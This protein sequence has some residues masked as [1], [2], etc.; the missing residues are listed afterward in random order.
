MAPPIAVFPNAF[1]AL[2]IEKSSIL[3]SFNSLPDISC[4]IELLL[5]DHYAWGVAVLSLV[6]FPV[7]VSIL[8]ELLRGCVYSGCCGEASTD[9]IP[10]IFYHIYTVIM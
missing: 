8:A 4:G 3:I 5:N 2:C 6:L 7:V 9:W 1:N 10:L